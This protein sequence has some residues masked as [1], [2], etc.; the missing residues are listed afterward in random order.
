MKLLTLTALLFGSPFW[1][2]AGTDKPC[3]KRCGAHAFVAGGGAPVIL[4][5][6]PAAK[7][8]IAYAVAVGEPKDQDGRSDK[9]QKKARKI[10]VTGP[11]PA[12]SEKD[13]ENQ[14]WLGVSI[15][16]VPESLLAQLGTQGQGL[17]I[18]NVVEDSPADEAGL[19]PHD[20]IVTIDGEAV[21]GGVENMV[22]RISGR[23]PGEKVNIVV[24]REGD[25]RT[26]TATL[27]SRADQEARQFEWKFETPP[28]A[29]I[30]DQIHTRGR[31]MFRDPEGKWIMRDLGDLTDL[32]VLPD[33][34]KLMLPESGSRTV[35]VFVEDGDTRVRTRVERDGSAIEV[36][37]EG[38]DQITVT[39][40][41]QDGNETTMTYESMEEL[42]NQDEEAHEILQGA[43]GA[44]VYQL[45]IDGLGAEDMDFDFD[46]DV[47]ADWGQSADPEWED[48]VQESLRNAQEAYHRALEEL[49]SLQGAPGAGLHFFG[50][51]PD[52]D[53]TPRMLAMR[54]LGKPKH[55]FEVRPDG[56]I[57]V[58]IRKGDS[59]LVQLYEDEDDLADRNPEFAK[60]YRDLMEAG[61]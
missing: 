26:V 14:G 47:D 45:K 19:E 22:T 28:D 58:R 24:L 18:Q 35:Q 32:H 48:R 6:G 34:V 12:G 60:K 8:G 9:G 44:G 29:E 36:E 20:I 1:F 30:E 17:L 11:K 53:G 43:G 52:G 59:E 54:P 37:Q 40:T 41:D 56:T 15:G 31:F 2:P 25:E 3:A 5:S 10:V 21:E 50:T 16:A 39:R 38:E 55:S 13:R 27:G 46:I 4:A 61:K 49:H 7:G 42:A 51:P 57:E 23:K 33:D